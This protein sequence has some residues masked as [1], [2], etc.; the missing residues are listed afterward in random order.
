MDKK[1]TLREEL[2][3]RLM[4]EYG[5]RIGEVLGL[6]FED[7]IVSDS[8]TYKLIIRNRVTD[9][10]YQRAKSLVNPKS[11]KDYADKIYKTYGVGFQVIYLSKEI[12]EIIDEYIED[13]RD[14]NFL[15][16]HKKKLDNLNFKTQADQVDTKIEMVENQYIFINKH[17]FTPLTATGWNY[18]VHKIFDMVN[19]PIDENVRETNLNHRFRHGFAMRKVKEEK[20]TPQQLA[21]ALRHSSTHSVQVY[22]NPDEED[23]LNLLKL[24]D[25]INL[26]GDHD[27][28]S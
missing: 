22:Y 27:F 1:F 12:V 19:L 3:F 13:T 8:G 16:D 2:V 17:H 9:R 15:K 23:Q 21:E 26:G 18:I 11:R 25:N 10:P 5:L 24:N 7:V 6:T 14:L 4:Y 20:Y 28:R